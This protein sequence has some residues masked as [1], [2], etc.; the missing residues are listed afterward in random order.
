[1]QL[2]KNSLLT[3]QRK[4]G[5][6]SSTVALPQVNVRN[7]Y[8]WSKIWSKM[9]MLFHVNKIAPAKQWR[10]V[11]LMGAT[12]VENRCSARTN[13]VRHAQ[14]T[15]ARSQPSSMVP[16]LHR[17]LCNCRQASLAGISMAALLI[18]ADPITSTR[19]W[20]PANAIC[21]SCRYVKGKT[22]DRNA[23]GLP[24]CD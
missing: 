8:C 3:D 9:Q 17:S 23:F 16:A 18:Q 6:I 11:P 7:T 12:Y 20:P 22:S 4:P 2:S 21:W 1:M 14:P 5:K 19:G 10:T 15:Y 13:K 24:S